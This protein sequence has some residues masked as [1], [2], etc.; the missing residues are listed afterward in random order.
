MKPY[1][2]L[3]N[4]YEWDV[5]A[6]GAIALT[7]KNVDFM[8]AV[9][10]VDSNYRKALPSNPESAQWWFDQSQNSGWCSELSYLSEL[11]KRIDRENSTRQSASGTQKNPDPEGNGNG[12]KQ[13]AA[14]LCSLGDISN[15]LRQGDPR[16]VNDLAQNCIGGNRRDTLSFASKFCTYCAEWKYGNNRY[17]IFDKIL[18]DVLPYYAWV[19][20]KEPYCRKYKGTLRSTIKNT[21]NGKTIDYEGYQRLIGHI[22]DKAFE[23]YGYQISRMHFDHLLWYYYK[24]DPRKII[25]LLTTYVNQ[26]SSLLFV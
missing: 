8:E 21:F 18:C 24:G 16:L 12:I 5:D 14:Y 26:K 4:P 7:A 15:L 23:L 6:N 13:T 11:V 19:Y 17:S 1:I 10:K 22:I 3:A 20:L 25:G 2:T 9:I